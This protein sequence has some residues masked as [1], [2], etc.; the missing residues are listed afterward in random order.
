M[1]NSFLLL[2]IILFEVT[3]NSCLSYGMRLVGDVTL[4][5]LPASLAIAVRMLANPWV[6][7]GVVL[8]IGYFL[9]F[10]AALSRIELSY[11]LPMT[12]LGYALTVFSAW[13]FL[14]ESIS[15]GRW[16]GTGLICM[17]T[18]LVGFS[19]YRKGGSR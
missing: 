12:A 9:C 14:G 17:G 1:K 16:W 11:L 8:L 7:G 6:M 18:V 19:E 5:G 15:A 4:A 3:G 13:G 10:L 2:L